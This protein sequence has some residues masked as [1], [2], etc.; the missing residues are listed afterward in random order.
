FVPYIN[1]RF[2]AE[3]VSSVL[4]FAFYLLVMQPFAGKKGV[5]GHLLAGF[6]AVCVLFIRLQFAFAFLPIAFVLLFRN[7]TPLAGWGSLIAGAIVAVG[8]CTAIDYWLYGC[9]TC[10]PYNYFDQN[11]L[12]NKAAGFGTM[13]AWWYITEFIGKG[14][15]PI[16]IGLLVLY[17]LGTAKQIKHPLAQITL[18]F[19]LGHCAIG[20]KEMRFLYPVLPSFLWCCFAGLDYVLQ[21]YNANK[22]VLTT[23]KV[24]TWLNMALLCFR[25]L[26]PAHERIAYYCF[27]DQYSRTHP[28]T[29]VGIG[30]SPYFLDVIELNFYKRKGIAIA[31]LNTEQQLDSLYRQH[32]AR[33]YL[34]I[35]HT[36]PLDR[37]WQGF[38]GE[39]LY[40]LF[41]NF[42]LQNNF[43]HWQER[44]D[45]WAVYRL[46]K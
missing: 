4:F 20:H 32:P 25:S 45:I 12:Q 38:K 28:T 22:P 36:A 27:I 24:F 40:S 2:S 7:K 14:V 39:R 16:S 26:T 21:T 10:T 33:P 35:S 23:L 8:C 41:P 34:Y 18:F 29:V 44:S 6:L 1:V 17:V 13:P 3:T 5:W 19:I 37:S 30:Q 9:Y 31:T 43:N 15:P 42:I 46:V 11:I